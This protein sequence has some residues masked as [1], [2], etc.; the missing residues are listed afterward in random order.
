[1]LLALR[2]LCFWPSHPILSSSS[3]SLVPTDLMSS[4]ATSINLCFGPLLGF[5]CLEV[6]TS[7]S[8]FPPYPPSLLSQCSNQSQCGPCSCPFFSPLNVPLSCSHS[9][10]SSFHHQVYFYF[11]CRRLIIISDLSPDHIWKHLLTTHSLNYL[12]K[13]TKCSSI[14]QLPPT[15]DDTVH[16]SPPVSFA[17]LCPGRNSPATPPVLLHFLS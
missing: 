5:H 17:S 14:Y 16:F 7:A 1:M 2:S 13:P 12:N 11:P 3:S 4:F 9:C 6:S 10:T 15:S 8:F